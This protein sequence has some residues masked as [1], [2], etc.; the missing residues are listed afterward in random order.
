MNGRIVLD[1]AVSCSPPGGPDWIRVTEGGDGQFYGSTTNTC[2]CG[3]HSPSWFAL[4][5]P[6]TARNS[7]RACPTLDMHF[8][9]LLSYVLQCDRSPPPPACG[10]AARLVFPSRHSLATTRGP[11]Y[12]QQNIA[13]PKAFTESGAK[14]GPLRSRLRSGLLLV[15]SGKTP[16]FDDA[17]VP[18]PAMIACARFRASFYV[19]IT[20]ECSEVCSNATKA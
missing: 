12:G 9:K 5:L 10:K 8:A 17:A 7:T 11:R 3:L 18:L 19:P 2:F 13:S 16:L 6:Q 20:G 14:P 15:R 4:R 1:A